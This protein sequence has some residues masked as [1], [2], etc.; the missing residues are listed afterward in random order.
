MAEGLEEGR[1]KGRAEGR[2]ELSIRPRFRQRSE[3][4]EFPKC[5]L[6]AQRNASNKCYHASSNRR[7]GG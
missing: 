7:V 1:V 4:V 3:Q 6:W 2:S 5:R